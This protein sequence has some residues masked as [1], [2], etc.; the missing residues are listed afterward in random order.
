MTWTT[1][2]SGL[3]IPADNEKILY[4]L[5]SAV[6]AGV[7][8]SAGSGFTYNTTAQDFDAAD[9]VAMDVSQLDDN[10]TPQMRIVITC[11]ISAV[12]ACTSFTPKAQVYVEA[13]TGS[14]G[15]VNTTVTLFTATA[16]TTAGGTLTTGFKSFDSGWV[17]FASLGTNISGYGVAVLRPRFQLDRL[18]A[19]PTVFHL[20]ASYF[21]R[22]A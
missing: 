6:A 20:T 10:G 5:N 22:V 19:D 9:R 2:A 1:P 4:D 17:S 16:L 18:T 13:A 3:A 7:G 11:Q 15:S 21:V 12:G 14:T 8:R